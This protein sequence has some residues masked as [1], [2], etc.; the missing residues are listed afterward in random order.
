MNHFDCSQDG[1]FRELSPLA[2]KCCKTF[3]PVLTRNFGEPKKCYSFQME[4][5]MLDVIPNG[6]VLWSIL[7]E[8]QTEMFIPFE[9]QL[10]LFQLCVR[11]K[12]PLRCHVIKVLYQ[13][14]IL[15]IFHTLKKFYLDNLTL[16]IRINRDLPN[17]S[18]LCQFPKI[19]SI[20]FDSETTDISSKHL[21]SWVS[22]LRTR[23]LGSRFQGLKVLGVNVID[24]PKLLYDLISSIPSLEWVVTNENTLG[25]NIDDIPYFRNNLIPLSQ[26]LINTNFFTVVDKLYK[27][28][29]YNSLQ[30]D[31]TDYGH[32]H[33]GGFGFLCKT[34]YAVQ[35]PL[36]DLNLV[37]NQTNK[38]LKTRP[39]RPRTKMKG[40][41][42]HSFKKSK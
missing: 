14:P 31:Y 20:F 33:E 2:Y 32:Y 34:G 3:V 27:E 15:S 6:N 1:E 17:V 13:Y 35:R 39:K 36:P 28:Q 25:F 37:K 42:G 5:D 12:M 24:G 8:L 4:C 41:F 7:F 29:C 11:F 10:K 21:R 19:R 18:S 16:D 22:Y 23:P 38:N 40:L 9:L 26:D 30:I